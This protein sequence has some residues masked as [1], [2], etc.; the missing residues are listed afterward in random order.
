MKAPILFASFLTLTIS[1]GWI[2]DN[3]SK[4]KELVKYGKL[5]T[6]IME[7]RDRK[8]ELFSQQEKELRDDL[9]NKK[10]TLQEV[11]RERDTAL[12]EFAEQQRENNELE[13]EL[14]SLQKEYESA[15]ATSRHNYD[16]AKNLE[17]QDYRDRQRIRQ[18]WADVKNLYADDAA[19]QSALGQALYQEANSPPSNPTSYTVL[20]GDTPL[21]IIPNP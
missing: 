13:R 8:G 14:G 3:N 16:A 2:A 10:A 7:D 15:C 9:V 18:L 6:A 5:C 11:F 4:N 21:F 20:G 1:L 19:A 12:K 17:E